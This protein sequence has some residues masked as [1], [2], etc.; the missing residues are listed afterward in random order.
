MAN[1]RRFRKT[2]F[3]SAGFLVSKTPGCGRL[4]A[5]N[6]FAVEVQTGES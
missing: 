6:G 2:V 5:G 3:A 1:A 4:R